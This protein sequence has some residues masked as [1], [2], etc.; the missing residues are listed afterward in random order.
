MDK[1]VKLSD[2]E[3]KAIERTLEKGD[4]VEITPTKSGLRICK[5]YRQEI[6]KQKIVS[7]A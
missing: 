7:P 1:L 5:V 3:I 6:E 2:K 4:R